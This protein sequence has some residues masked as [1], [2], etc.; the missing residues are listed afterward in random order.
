[1]PAPPAPISSRT[2]AFLAA[3]QPDRYESM[4]KPK[5]SWGTFEVPIRLK[6]SPGLEVLAIRLI[7]L[8]G[9][10]HAPVSIGCVDRGLRLLI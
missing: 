1:M 8:T 10:F 9:A 5:V 3:R 4:P 6:L 7:R 2:A